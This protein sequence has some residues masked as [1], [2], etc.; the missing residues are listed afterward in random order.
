MR[1]LRLT[2]MHSTCDHNC[3]LLAVVAQVHVQS[4]AEASKVRTRRQEVILIV[5]VEVLDFFLE[6]GLQQ[7]FHAA[8]R[9]VALSGKL[10]HLLVLLPVLLLDHVG[11]VVHEAQLLVVVEIRGNIFSDR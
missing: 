5:L 8:L 4:G 11:Y 6:G 1:R 9:V 7:P 3:L 10:A 2:R